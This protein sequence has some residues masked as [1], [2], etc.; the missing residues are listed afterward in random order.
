MVDETELDVMDADHE[1]RLSDRYYS[2]TM[3]SKENV[4]EYIRYKESLDP[5]EGV[6]LDLIIGRKEDVGVVA[7]ARLVGWFTI[8]ADQR[9]EFSNKVGALIDE[10]RIL[11]S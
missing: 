1:S 3:K 2:K 10:Y 8:R 4:D 5:C 9:K 7:D 6:T 11:N